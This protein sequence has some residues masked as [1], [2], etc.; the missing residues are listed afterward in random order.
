MGYP[1]PLSFL[2]GS[3]RLLLYLERDV[4]IP[5]ASGGSDLTG[6]V[7]V[8]SILEARLRP[9]GSQAFVSRAG[10]ARILTAIT[11]IGDDVGLYLGAPSLSVAAGIPSAPSTLCVI[12]FTT[13]GG[14]SM[15]A[16]VELP[17]SSPFSTTT[18][19][20]GDPKKR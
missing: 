5:V 3:C 2:E 12:I 11:T 16:E 15:V 6:V 20:G 10:H 19:G 4:T 18:A 14:V 8:W 9:A 1:V 13:T 7:W 17:I